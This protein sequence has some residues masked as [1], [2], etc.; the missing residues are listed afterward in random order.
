MVLLLPLQSLGQCLLQ[1]GGGCREGELDCDA[2]AVVEDSG[3]VVS[4]RGG[5]D[6]QLVVGLT[7][8]AESHHVYTEQLLHC[9]DWE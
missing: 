7:C 8:K 1:V 5:Q 2:A 4:F 3:K 6:G 9:A